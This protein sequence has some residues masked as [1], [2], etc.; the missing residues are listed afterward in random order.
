[1][2][3]ASFGIIG[4]ADGPTAVFVGERVET[5]FELFGMGFAAGLTVGL[6]I[7]A[8]AAVVVYAVMKKKNK[9]Q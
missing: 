8:V 5:V 2:N 4:G 6:V 3:D 7:G 9:K 1:M